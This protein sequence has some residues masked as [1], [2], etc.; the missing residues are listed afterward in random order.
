M[1][2][3]ANARV[4]G[5]GFKVAPHAD[6]A[7]GKLEAVAFANMGLSGRVSALVAA[8]S[9]HAPDAPARQRGR[10]R[11]A[12]STASRRRP[13]TRRTASGTRRARPRSSSRRCRRPCASWSRRDERGGAGRVP[14]G[15]RGRRSRPSRPRA[16][17]RSTPRCGAWPRRRGPPSRAWCSSA[18]GARAPRGR[19]P[20]AL[21]TPSSSSRTTGPSTRALSRAGLTGKRPGLMALVSGW[22]PPTQ[23]SLRFEDLGIHVKAAVLRCDTWTR[24]TSGAAA[25]TSASAGSSSRPAS[26]TRGTRPPGRGSWTGWS[27]RTARRGPGRGPGCPS[28][29]TPRPTGARRCAPR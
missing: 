5:G 25:T 26:C 9:R 1:L 11:R 7:D 23:F 13:R 8:P 16:T 20:G 3:V 22:L 12:S 2:I 27:R 15:S 10:R 24:E 19:T 29:S 28:A 21:T 4:F 17:R 18:R 6:V 14:A